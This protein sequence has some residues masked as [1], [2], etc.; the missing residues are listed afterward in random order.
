MILPEREKHQRSIRYFLTYLV[1]WFGEQLSLADAP[2]LS[3][4]GDERGVSPVIGTVL[5]VALTVLLSALIGTLAFGFASGMAQDSPLVDFRMN[6]NRTTVVLTH[7][8]GD[9]VAGEDVHIVSG[10]RG[11][12]GNYAG[13]DRQA[14][15]TV[16]STVTPGT[17]CQ[18]SGVTSGD[19]YLVWRSNGRSATLFQGRIIDD[20]VAPTPTPTPTATPT[21]TPTATPTP[22]PTATPTLT[23]TTTPTPTPTATPTLTPTATPTPTPTA[24]P[25]PTPTATPTPSP[26]V[27]G[28][29]LR[30][31]ST[32]SNTNYE[33]MYDID[34][35]ADFDRVEV[36]FDNQANDWGDTTRSTSAERGTVTFSQGGQQGAT[37]EITI[38]VFNTDG[39][40]TDTVSITDTAN[41]SFQSSGDLTENDSPSFAGTVVDDLGGD[42]ANYEVS[43]N[44]PDRSNFGSVRV[45]YTN[46]DS[47]GADATYTSTD[48]RHN[49]DNYAEADFGGTAG[50]EYRIRAE[51]LDTDGVVVDDR[52]VT[53]VADGDDPSGNADLRRASS[54]TLSSYSVKDRTKTQTDTGK[55]RVQ[56]QVSDPNGDFSQLEAIFVNT[57]NSWATQTQSSS[58]T[59]GNLQYDTGG[60][61][62][63]RY[64]ITIRVLDTDGVVVDEVTVTDT[65]DGTNP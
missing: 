32:N 41:G 29:T 3:G 50:D 1:Q 60:V 12:L 9:T 21:P 63:D 11:W 7:A 57:D 23:P 52:V 54:P 10:S 13:T 40:V 39:T 26:A 45:Q 37:Y 22:T 31:T 24:T 25:T 17:E 34:G 58:K 51:L 19:I 48:P 36:T 56:Y 15:D 20:G 33:L 61:S 64:R 55:Y 47:G 5:L 16:I 4:P 65:A 46:F 14:C 8:G 43:Y 18:I 49:I 59:N 42:E 62:G 2:P 53:D 27:S 35:T 30:D 44:V 38:R 6:Q 28:Y